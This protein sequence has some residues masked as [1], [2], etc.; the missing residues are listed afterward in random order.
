MSPPLL[1]SWLRRLEGLDETDASPRGSDRLDVRSVQL[2]SERGVAA[3]AVIFASP[4]FT[5][6]IR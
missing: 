4:A 6:F 3:E 5:V 1:V 2:L